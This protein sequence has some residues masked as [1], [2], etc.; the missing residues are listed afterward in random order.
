MEWE[1]QKQCQVTTLT[2]SF[3]FI[4]KGE[5]RISQWCNMTV[6]NS[7]QLDQHVQV[8]RW[9]GVGCGV[10]GVLSQQHNNNS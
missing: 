1:L 7:G 5:A 9:P 8:T 6:G 4:L 10:S 3:N 2:S